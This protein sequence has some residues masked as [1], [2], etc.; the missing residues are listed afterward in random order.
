VFTVCVEDNGTKQY[1]DVT[2]GGE[3]FD[4][5]CNLGRGQTVEVLS[6]EFYADTYES[7]K[8]GETMA[9]IR[10]SADSVKVVSKVGAHVPTMVTQGV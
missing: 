2:A 8:T 5:C 3:L 9:T 1:Y 6:S 10:V 4:A 7:K